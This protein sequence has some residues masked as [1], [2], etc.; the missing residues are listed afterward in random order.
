MSSTTDFQAVPVTW[1]APPILDLSTGM[2]MPWLLNAPSCD[3]SST[4]TS[5]SLWAAA[6]ALSF[7]SKSVLVMKS[8]ILT[9]VFAVKASKTIRYAFWES[10]APR[11]QTFSGPEAE[12]PPELPPHAVRAVEAV[13]RVTARA[14]RGSARPRPGVLVV[15]LRSALIGVLRSPETVHVWKF[16]PHV[17]IAGTLDPSRAPVKGS[18]TFRQPS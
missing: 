5:G 6:A 17:G 9:P 3:P 15:L 4:T 7:V 8:W 2:M 12:P 13:T 11:T 1:S 10:P 16:S 14:A 18:D